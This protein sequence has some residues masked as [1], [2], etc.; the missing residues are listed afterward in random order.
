MKLWHAV[1]TLVLCLSIK[2][3][4]PFLVEVTRLNFFDYL[5]RSHEIVESDQIILVDIDE[6]SI[7]EYGQWPWPRK[8]LAYAL[9]HIPPN[10]LVGL[11]LIF[12]E[13]DRFNTDLVLSDTLQYYPS[14]LATAPTNQIQTER[15]LHVGTATL[16]RI[17]AQEYTIDYPGILLPIEI[18]ANS[19]TGYGA[20]SSAADI[21]GITRR[22]PIVVSSNNKL[23][24]SFALEVIR[25]AVG[26]ISYQL[27]TNESGIQWAR[28][29]KFNPVDTTFD[30]TVYNTYWNKFKRV[31]LKD[32]R[33]ET[34]SEGSILIVGPT[35]EGTNIISTPV[36]GMYPHDVQAN[37][38][39]TII[40]GTTIKRPDEYIFFELIGTLLI[41]LVIL[42][43]LSRASIII[44]GI[45]FIGFEV[46]TSYYA[47]NAFNTN[48]ILIDSI[49]PSLT[50]LLVFAHGAFA[51]FYTQFKLRQ[52]IQKQFGTYLSPDMVK[53]LQEDP[54]LLK[55]GGERKEMTFM[56]MDICGFTP[57]SE[58]YKNKDDPEGLVD[59]I[60]KFLDMQTKIILN[61]GGTI[62][63]Y[64]GDCIMSFWNAPLDCTNHAE[65]AVKSA[66]EILIATKVLNEE[67]KPL[68]LPP[69]KVGIGINTGDCI[70]GNMGSELRFD[71]SVIGDAVNLGARLESQTRNYD[72]VD[73]LLGEETYRQCPERSFTEVDRITV[74][75]KTE[76]VTVFTI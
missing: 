28:V 20:I 54:S 6:A 12:S 1:I 70:V 51:Q 61:N 55:L 16:G 38:I 35:F 27:K 41:G 76:P 75:G 9:N 46:G 47:I 26:D 7:Q 29:P 58:H 49:I 73:V 4:D 48:F 11:T 69:I 33:S 65:L 56:F 52:Q 44:S 32:I 17:P 67:L 68:K 13:E 59:L 31:S 10:N 37:L 3:W 15:E 66:E 19:A 5:Q 30:G 63:K 60:N 36:G 72:G 45:L 40:D 39:K 18:L 42:I 25:V 43:L 71:Y 34:I 53:M 57:I 50:F 8:D 14:I 2:V 62:D 74:K 24:P 64:M 23:Y 21:D 22:L